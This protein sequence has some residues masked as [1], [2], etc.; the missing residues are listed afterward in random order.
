MIEFQSLTLEGLPF[1]RK[2]TFDFSEPGIRLI[3]GNNRNSSS[4]NPNAAGKS[5]FFAQ[6]PELVLS[7]MM[8]GTRRDFTRS[9]TVTVDLRKG[10]SEYSIS[11]SFSPKEKMVISRKGKDLEIRELSECKKKIRSLIPYTPDEVKTF[12]FLDSQLPHPLITG[13]TAS[14]KNFFT[15]FFKL[16]ALSFMKKSVSSRVTESRSANSVL[17][18]LKKSHEEASTR[19]DSSIEEKEALLSRLQSKMERISS[20]MR[21]WSRAE[22]LRVLISEHHKC[23]DLMKSQEILTEAD[24]LSHRKSREKS[25]SRCRAAIRD[26][27]KYE[28]WESSSV[29]RAAARKSLKKHGLSSVEE[30]QALVDKKQRILDKKISRRED[31][32]LKIEERSRSEKKIKSELRN[33]SED[34]VS[35]KEEVNHLQEHSDSCPTCGG[36]YDNKKAKERLRAAKVSYKTL[37]SRIAELTVS[38][39]VMMQDSSPAAEEFDEEEEHKSIRG[40][41]SVLRVL[42][43]EDLQP[44]GGHTKDYWVDHERSFNK[45]LYSLESGEDA[46]SAQSEWDKLPDS[47]RGASVRDFQNRQSEFLRISEKK[48][49]LEMEVSSSLEASREVE[50]LQVRMQPLQEKAEDLD[51]LMVLEEAFSK[52]GVE[53]TIIKS[54]CVKL[55]E[56]VNEYAKLI[57]PEDYHFEF[58]L[59]TQFSILVSR[60]Y[61]KKTITSDVRKLSGAEKRLFSLVLLI[62]LLVFVPKNHR[63]NLLI[64]DECDA[65]MGTENRDRFIRFLPVLQK[66]IPSIVV[67]TPLGHQPYLTISPKIYTVVKERNGTASIQ[68]GVV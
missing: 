5:F 44:P 30:L 42:S 24:L 11:R 38:L 1:F 53:S 14:R 40:L 57:F 25:I 20:S 7:E 61:G 35:L 13:D 46:L 31:L 56:K 43:T 10:K 28:E 6:L 49:A 36:E 59:D 29:G 62:S 32:E 68:E 8:H 64:L 47:V 27:D 33:Q 60:K 23:I 65:N 12:L 41:Q 50:R 54:I 4:N 21:D 15:S 34:L 26:W 48:Q 58:E 63:S 17:V 3:L 52:R 2:Q 51:A 55:E 19:V 37:Q 16:G 18:E 9:G 66:A 39:Q 22:S 45:E 67:I